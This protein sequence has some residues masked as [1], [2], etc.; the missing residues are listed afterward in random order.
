[1]SA[2]AWPTQVQTVLLDAGGVLVDLDYAYLARLI[3]VQRG[4]R[5]S[6]IEGTE[7]SRLEAVARRQIH[8]QVREGERAGAVWRDYFHII[9]AG[10]G[11][12]AARQSDLIDSLWEAHQRFGL[13]TTPVEGGP[14][15]VAR[16]RK[17]GFTIGVVSNAEGNVARDLDTAGYQGLFATVVDS[18]VVGVEKPDPEIFR[19]ALGRLDADPVTTVFVGDLPAVDVV[20]ARAA[21]ITPILIDRHDLYPDSGTHRIKSIRDLPQLLERAPGHN[22]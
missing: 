14:A 16:I 2:L 12:P 20:G 3:D 1:M 21:G 8:E 13:W 11:I 15:A 5:E 4:P 10:A 22:A 9:L 6:R 18:H 19:I 7:L 17:S